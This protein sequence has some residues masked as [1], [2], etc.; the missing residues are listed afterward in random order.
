MTPEAVYERA[1][2]LT[3]DGLLEVR[4]GRGPN[5]GVAAT[6]GNVAALIIGALA[7][8]RLV[9]TGRLTRDTI[10]AVGKCPVSGESASFRDA[11]ARMISD[12]EWVARIAKLVVSGS[13]ATGEIH[14]HR[15]EVAKFSGVPMPGDRLHTSVTLEFDA[16]HNFD[17]LP[18]LLH[19]ADHVARS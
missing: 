12:R 5:S 15:N 14:Y 9:D 8:V 19:V 13:M 16:T 4:E 6:P 17:A 1:R 18:D 10:T 11:L 3:R 2:A 7:S